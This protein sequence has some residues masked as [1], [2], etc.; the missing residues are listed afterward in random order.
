MCGFF[1]HSWNLIGS[2]MRN[3]RWM[4]PSS[5][6]IHG[7]AWS[8]LDPCHFYCCCG[9]LGWAKEPLGGSG[10]WAQ[11]SSS[12]T[13]PNWVLSICHVQEHSSKINMWATVHNLVASILF[14][15]HLNLVH[16]CGTPAGIMVQNSDMLWR[17]FCSHLPPDTVSCSFLL[18]TY[19]SWD[20]EEL[21]S[22]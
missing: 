12:W 15:L 6:S 8:G 5:C 16:C 11:M 3:R 13:E 22:R 7:S 2:T 1:Q 9:S 10:L 18:I 17:Q 4:C 19:E 21:Q 20:I 14:V